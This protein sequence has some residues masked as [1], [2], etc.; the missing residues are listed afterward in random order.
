M[1]NIPEERQYLSQH[2]GRL[3]SRKELPLKHQTTCTIHSV[4]SLPKKKKKIYIYILWGHEGAR[5]ISKQTIHSLTVR[6]PRGSRIR[7]YYVRWCRGESSFNPNYSATEL[8]RQMYNHSTVCVIAQQYSSVA[9]LFRFPSREEKTQRSFKNVTIS[10]SFKL[11]K[12]FTSEISLIKQ[13]TVRIVGVKQ[14]SLRRFSTCS[15]AAWLTGS[16]NLSQ[17]L[18]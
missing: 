3:K 9:F 16:R 7:V 15:R 8:Y 11:S 5:P 13:R 10:F 4:T 12:F 17:F 1:R 6:A 14:S 18:W 2:G